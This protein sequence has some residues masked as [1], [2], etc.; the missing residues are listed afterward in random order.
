M[1]FTFVAVFAVHARAMYWSFIDRASEIFDSNAVMLSYNFE[2]E[3]LWMAIC[4]SKDEEHQLAAASATA[5]RANSSSP[6]SSAN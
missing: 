6:F 5:S 3:S 1:S 2:R 4:S